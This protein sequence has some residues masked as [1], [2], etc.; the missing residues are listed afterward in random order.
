MSWLI[1]K[2]GKNI[3]NGQSVMNISLPVFI[4]QARTM[5]QIFAYEFRLAPYYFKKAFYSQDKYEKLKYL[6]AFIVTQSYSSITIS[7]PFSPRL[8]ETYQTKIG[9]LNMYIE[10]TS[11]K[12]LT[13]NFYCIDDDKTFT[14][15]G[16]ITTSASTGANSCK[17]IKTGR[18][19]LKYS[20]GEIYNF[21]FPT[22]S[23]KGTT[24]GKKEFALKNYSLVEDVNNKLIS[25]VHYLKKDSKGFFKGIF[26]KKKNKEN[27]IKFPDE[28]KGGIYNSNDIKINNEKCKHE[29]NEN[30]NELVPL[31]GRWT[32]DLYFED[33]NY[34]KMNDMP[35]LPMMEMKF[36]LPSDTSLR[37]DLIAFAKGDLNLAQIKKEEVEEKQRNDRKLR[38]KYAEVKK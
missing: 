14:Y 10:Q 21:Y 29:I 36:M 22:I 1:K 12:P 5:L 18:S 33:K 28:I 26:G 2:I 15:S 9:D 30:A 6:T 38:E 13:A 7:K 20:T 19:T 34:W 4:F 23:I 16:N 25:A 8:G 37:E 35:L 32:V 3:V 17:A 31:S 24:V 11:S 27:A